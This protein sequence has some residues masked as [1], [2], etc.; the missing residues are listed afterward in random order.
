MTGEEIL[1]LLTEVIRRTFRQPDAPVDR[2]TTAM[3]I[4]GW[5]SLSH[6]MLILQVEQRFAVR[7]PADRVHELDNVGEL[8]DLIA[9][10]GGRA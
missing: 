1:P 7:L 2:D 5:D 3:D 9:E 8:A 6:T 4:N 10:A